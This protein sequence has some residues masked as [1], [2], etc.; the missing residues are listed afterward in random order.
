ML[1]EENKIFKKSK[2]MPS[3]MLI[4]SSLFYEGF[5]DGCCKGNPGQAGIGY[6]INNASS[7]KLTMRSEY[8]GN[9]TNNQAEML[10]LILLLGDA[11]CNGIKNLNVYGDSS[12][13]IRAMSNLCQI[14]SPYLVFYFATARTLQNKFTAITFNHIN[15]TLNYQADALANKSCSK[16]SLWLSMF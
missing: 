10:A 1:L 6:I 4:D 5:F 16:S 7:Q 9:R 12:L 13:V 2:F 14:S 11:Y 8:I 3:D 15:R